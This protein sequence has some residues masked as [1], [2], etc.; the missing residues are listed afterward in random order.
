MPNTKV[1]PVCSNHQ[2]P[3][4]LDHT[5]HQRRSFSRGKQR[6][7]NSIRIQQDNDI[8]QPKLSPRASC[9][10]VLTWSWH[11]EVLCSFLTVKPALV[12]QTICVSTPLV[13]YVY[14]TRPQH[15]DL[16]VGLKVGL[17]ERMLRTYTTE[18]NTN[19]FKFTMLTVT[20]LDCERCC[21]CAGG[22][23]AP[24]ATFVSISVGYAIV[25][26]SLVAFVEP[27]AAGSGI[28]EIKTYLN[29]IHIKGLLTVS[30]DISLWL[31]GRHLRNCALTGTY[32]F[33]P[34]LPTPVRY[35]VVYGL[36]GAMPVLLCVACSLYLTSCTRHATTD[37]VPGLKP[38][39]FV[40]SRLCST[41]P[42]MPN[43]HCYVLLSFVAHR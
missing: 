16:I 42:T 1:Q 22:F 19:M 14:Q 36:C 9:F 32:A 37:R 41:S 38:D 10:L 30:P 28:P 7:T 23:W 26:G 29:G 3:Y 21:L 6:V 2:V 8:S 20:C 11:I 12:L 5:L 35:L 40:A 43:M 31:L 39:W 13:V 24:Y 15:G 25:A 4:I 27:L 33:G 17:P 18:Y 34:S